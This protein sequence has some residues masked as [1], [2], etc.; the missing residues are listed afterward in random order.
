MTLP[1]R[2]WLAALADMD[3]ALTAAATALDDYET[4]YPALPTETHA[5]V[6]LADLEDRLTGWDDRLVAAGRLAEGLEREFAEQAE[7]VGR[8]VEAFDGWR[9]GIQQ[10][11]SPPT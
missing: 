6:P 7:A 1:T 10:R 3:A 5:P 2:D 11:T 8:W 4:R 9:G